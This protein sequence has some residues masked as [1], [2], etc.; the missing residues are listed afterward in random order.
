PSSGPLPAAERD[1]QELEQAQRSAVLTRFVVAEE[2]QAP[3]RGALPRPARE[4]AAEHV[5][6]AVVRRALA[7]DGELPQE[8]VVL[9]DAR[10]VAVAPRDRRQ[11]APVAAD[12]LAVDVAAHRA[13]AERPHLDV[14]L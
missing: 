11:D 6:A 5:V 7:A 13:V 2:R 8:A 1:R 12:A 3:G 10:D 14:V 4:H 9:L